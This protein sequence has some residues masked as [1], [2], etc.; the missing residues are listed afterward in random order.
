MGGRDPDGKGDDC[1]EGCDK[2]HDVETAELV[3]E[4]AGEDA[5][6]DAVR[7]KLVDCFC[8]S[9][10]RGNATYLAALRMGIK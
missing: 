6:E 8:P 4:H 5:T 3:G 10:R 7:R 1:G 9:Q 2:D